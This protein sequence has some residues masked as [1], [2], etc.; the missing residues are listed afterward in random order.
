MARFLGAVRS[1][2]R[3][4][5][6]VFG[7]SP[8]IILSRLRKGASVL[9]GMIRGNDRASVAMPIR[10]QV[11][12]TDRCN[13][14]CIMCNR[15]TRPG[16]QFRL[17][18]NIDDVTFKRLVNEI[19]PFYV[20][21]NGLG[22][23]ALHKSID[24][25][26]QET[27]ARHITTQ[28]PSNMSIRKV[29]LEKV[30]PN[31]PS[32][33]TFSM[34]GATKGSFEAISVNSVYEEC[35]ALFED[36][37]AKVNQDE[38]E[39]R[40]LCALQAKNLNDYHGFY[41]FLTRWNLLDRLMLVPVFDYAENRGAHHV[42]PTADELAAATAK[43]E[44]DIAACTDP[45]KGDFLRRWRDTMGQL[46]A[47]AEIHETG[48]CL[49]PWFS[50]YI[51]ATGKVLPCC[52][53]TDEQHVLGNVFEEDFST[54]WNGPRYQEFRRQLRDNRGQLSGCRNCPRNDAERIRKYNPLS[55]IRSQWHL[56]AKPGAP[57]SGEEIRIG[58]AGSS[59]IPLTIKGKP[60]AEAHKVTVN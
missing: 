59:P 32:V 6:N 7:R 47:N 57:V 13:F 17:T 36:F 28:M 31:P 44:Q 10:M 50:T 55:L 52:Y 8:H 33:L 41:E 5:R 42:V 49:V 43:I 27:R 46:R 11:E 58:G 38:V 19:D 23:P 40:I 45:R 29:M 25:I 39:I 56:D 54:I 34:H 24:K 16:V 21:L 26:L 4:F 12:V 22:E 60:S 14:D 53:L 20:T 37:L 15:L 18:N 3:D 9:R 2:S 1:A 51:T 30:A 48:P 35:I